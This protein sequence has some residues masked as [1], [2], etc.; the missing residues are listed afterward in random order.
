MALQT[1]LRNKSRKR[2]KTKLVNLKKVLLQLKVKEDELV[3]TY[4][5][6]TKI[7]AELTQLRTQNVGKTSKATDLESAATSSTLRAICGEFV[8]V[9]GNSSGTP[10]A[11]AYSVLFQVRDEFYKY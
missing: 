2:L 6:Q 9:A 7:L 5:R 1:L 4:D 10:S 11:A 3:T 8:C